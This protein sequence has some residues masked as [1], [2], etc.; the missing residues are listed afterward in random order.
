MYLVHYKKIKKT[1]CIASYNKGFF[2]DILHV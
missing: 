1:T 2:I